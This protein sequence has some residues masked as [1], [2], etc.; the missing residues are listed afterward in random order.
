MDPK[1]HKGV[2]FLW[3]REMEMKFFSFPRNVIQNSTFSALPYMLII[4]LRNKYFLTK[5][6]HFLLN[7]E[8]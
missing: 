4:S 1:L 6:V 3:L 5:N 2:Y 8:F 7:L